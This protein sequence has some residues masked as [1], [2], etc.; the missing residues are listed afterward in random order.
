MGVSRSSL[1]L[2]RSPRQALTR[3]P[4]RPQPK[5]ITFTHRSPSFVIRSHQAPFPFTSS[6]SIVYILR[7]ADKLLRAALSSSTAPPPAHG[8]A[9][10]L[11]SESPVGPY[12][13]MMLSFSGLERLE[14]GQRGIEG[15]FAAQQARGTAIGAGGARAASVGAGAGSDGRVKR[16][17]EE[18]DGEDGR[19]EKRRRTVKAKALE[20]KGSSAATVRS[21]E[22]TIEVLPDGTE[23]LVLSSSED[24]G[25]ARPPAPAR[26]AKRS[27]A[28][29]YTCTR[30]A[31]VLC[32]PGGVAERG[33]EDE[34]REALEREKAEHADW[35]VA[36]DL[37]GAS[38]P[39]LIFS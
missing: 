35:H 11:S 6:L 8:N 21:R 22:A 10:P 3:S 7:V 37:V 28:P 1:P 31:R 26:R 34:V 5:T 17:G 20:G 30:C 27:R 4:R 12:S 18:R 24:D 13:N 19:A 29:T 15:F 32:V 36:R 39:L 14:D 23:A 16:E 38:L 25:G 2:P 9:P 33:A